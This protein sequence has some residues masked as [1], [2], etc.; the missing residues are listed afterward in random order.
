MSSSKYWANNFIRKETKECFLRI[1]LK[2]NAVEIDGIP[3]EVGDDPKQLE[4]AALKILKAIGVDCEPVDIEAIHRLPA[5]LGIKP[6]IV[7]FNNRK[8]A[9]A[10]RSNKSKLKDLK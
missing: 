4:I 9:V 7:R 2:Y 5:R 6:T 3:T 1:I 10:A 8:T